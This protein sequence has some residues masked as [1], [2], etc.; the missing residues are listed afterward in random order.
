MDAD[1]LM[2]DV[3]ILVITVIVIK[4]YHDLAF[5]LRF[6]LILIYVLYIRIDLKFDLDDWF[7]LT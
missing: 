1:Y 7:R 6:K 2:N 5:L 4:F 3:I